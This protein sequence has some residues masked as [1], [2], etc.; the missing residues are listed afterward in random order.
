M[1]GDRRDG[2]VDALAELAVGIG[3]PI[4][5]PAHLLER[6][7]QPVQVLRQELLAKRRIGARPRELI[8]S[9]QVALAFERLA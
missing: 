5:G 2:E 6:L 1:E 9:G 4:A 3:I 7:E 8:L